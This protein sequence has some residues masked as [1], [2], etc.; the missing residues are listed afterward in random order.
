MPDRPRKPRPGFTPPGDG[1]SHLL[2]QLNSAFRR[3][4]QDSLR[5]RDLDLSMTH[6][7]ALFAL[8]EEPGLAGAQLARRAMTSA[9]AMHNVL[10]KL[11]HAQLIARRPHPESRRSD[12]WTLTPAGRRRLA[13]ARS[14]AEPIMLQMV[15]GLSAAERSEFQ[16]LLGLCIAALDGAARQA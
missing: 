6:M 14:V 11:E 15:S 9:Q 16:R 2:R 3:R 5:D 13:R 10:R 1:I 4:L 8:Q 7:V 12:C